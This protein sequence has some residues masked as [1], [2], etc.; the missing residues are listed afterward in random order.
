MIDRLLILA[1]E[2]RGQW[3]WV[4]LHFE[5]GRI[6]V[7][8][9]QYRKE[10]SEDLVFHYSITPSYWIEH[11]RIDIAPFWIGFPSDHDLLRIDQRGESFDRAGIDD[12]RV[13]GIVL[14][15]CAVQL[16]NGPFAFRHEFVYHR[17]MHIR[18]SG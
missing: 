17:A 12:L 6:D 10:R 8:V 2:G 5:N 13:I 7:F 3:F 9:C 4:F 11:R 18:V 1:K 16:D 15:V 14:R